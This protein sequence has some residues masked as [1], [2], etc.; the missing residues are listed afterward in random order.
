M[1]TNVIKNLLMEQ[2]LL[3]LQ[4]LKIPVVV[5]K[6]IAKVFSILT[7]LPN[8]LLL[9]IVD[10]FLFSE[11]YSATMLIYTI[12]WLPKIALLLFSVAIFYFEFYGVY[13][14]LELQDQNLYLQVGGLFLA[15]SGLIILM[16]KGY[17]S[18]IE[19]YNLN[20]LKSVKEHIV[21]GYFLLVDIIN[22]F[23]VLIN[24]FLVVNVRKTFSY[25][26]DPNTQY[27]YLRYIFDSVR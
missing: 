2:D 12:M 13:Y 11:Q 27:G 1:I 17:L 7:Y 23:L 16:R 3:L 20:K 9:L 14:L 19:K 26:Y 25:K 6:F 21:L 8:Y 18:L 10:H 5:I 15:F 22:V 24:T 4:I